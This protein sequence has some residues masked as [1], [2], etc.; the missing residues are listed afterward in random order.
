MYINYPFYNFHAIKAAYI[1]VSDVCNFRCKICKLPKIKKRS[2]VPIE[3]LKIK[4]KKAAGLGLNNL[5]FTGQEV[6]L[7]PEIDEIIRFSFKE[8]KAN[9]ITFNTNGLAF[10]ND[11]T[12]RKLESVKQ[13]LN[14]V[15]IGISVNFYDRETFNNW[16]DHKGEV[17]KN[18]V[19]G[20]K[21]AV[22]SD[23]L[24]ITS[25]DVILK[26]DIEIIKILDFLNK[27]SNRKNGYHEGLRII[28]LMPFGYTQG[29]IYKKL[30]HRL[31]GTNKKIL[32][33]VKKYPGKIHF[34]S[35]PICLFNQKDL[36]DEK[37]FI[38]NFH[39]SFEN[40]LL[41]QYD[42]NI[43]ETYYPGKTENWLINKKEL[44]DAYNKMFCY[45]D[46]CQGCYY[47][48]KC[49]GIQREYLKFYPKKEVNNEIKLLKLMNWK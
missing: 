10:A 27:V 4:I 17:F 2:F 28:D 6:I 22:N 11:L 19:A 1:H 38:Y 25:L 34:E 26:K 47:K 7:H 33:I 41:I 30:K 29:K 35:F 39:L 13:Y 16:S 3:T 9:Y 15:Y 8:C 36:K 40:N 5:I 20:L 46:E 42:P 48:D 24:N 14:K 45:I 12:W 21:R 23:F 49:Y 32:E 37:Y 18:W 31:V 43:Y 44:L